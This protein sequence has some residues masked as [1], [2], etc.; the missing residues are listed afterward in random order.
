M[1][2]SRIH[3]VYLGI[4]ALIA[5]TAPVALAETQWQPTELTFTGP[6]GLS[7]IGG[8][9]PFL[10]YRL[11]VTFKQGDTTYTVPGFFDGVDNSG[12]S[13]WKTRFTPDLAGDWTY[14]ASF[15]TGNQVAVSLDTDA[16]TAAGF[17]GQTGGFTVA[18]RDADAPGFLSKGRLAYTGEHYLQTLG[19]GKYW[20]KTGTDS[21]ENLLGYQGFDNTRSDY[22]GAG[23]EPAGPESTRKNRLGSDKLHNYQPH[24]RDWE[25]G[26]PT[27][28]NTGSDGGKGLIGAINYLHDLGDDHAGDAKVNSVYFLPNNIGGD[29][30]D[31]SPYATQI[32]HSGET[33]SSSVNNDVTR[34]DVSKLNQWNTAFQHAQEKGIH[35]HVVLNEA[36]SDNKLELDDATL[37]VERKLFYRELVARFA[38]HNALQWNMSEEYN[39]DLE[40]SPE[41]VREFAEYLDAV[42]AYDH[43]TTVHNG[44]FLQWPDTTKFPNQHEDVSVGERNEHEPY[45]GPEFLNPATNEVYSNAFHDLI[46]FQSYAEDRSGADAEYFFKRTAELGKPIPF[47]HDEP[48]SLDALTPGTVRKKITW[49]HFLSGGGGIEGFVRN[50]DQTLENFRQ[51]EDVWRE[52]AIAREFFEQ[53]LPFWEM[54][55][56]D[57]LLTGEDAFSGDNN[58][59]EVFAL[60][61]E[62]YALY[63][64]DTDNQQTGSL[65][66]TGFDDTFSLRWFDPTSGQFVGEAFMLQ[67]GSVVDLPDTP[68][69]NAADDDDWVALVNVPEP[70]SG[71]M[72]LT[73][74]GWLT[75]RR[76]R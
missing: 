68:G 57:G 25:S 26:D 9:N 24:V 6:Q 72:L 16:G 54:T 62:V 20:L 48:E 47:M 50:E 30:Q 74:L 66:L 11:N 76:R 2:P 41:Q 46:S 23:P 4:A 31:T 49:D 52:T 53:N 1:F 35:L 61:G 59:G 15:R 21:P 3:Q 65:D 71:I 7:E 12:N 51:Y 22:G 67:G 8:A 45:L 10:D 70:A 38:H 32:D 27:F 37:G 40:L 42:D 33:Y 19:D 55:P 44:N 43:P 60:L 18:P 39:R 69:Q 73:G 5:A 58:P 17:N 29:G 34:F 63:L 13:V 64:P 56:S 36:E 28:N 75:A 14:T